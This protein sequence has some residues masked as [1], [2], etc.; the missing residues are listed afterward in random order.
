VREERVVS[1]VKSER[2]KKKDIRGIRV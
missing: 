2:N 1:E